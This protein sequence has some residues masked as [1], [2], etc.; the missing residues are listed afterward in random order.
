MSLKDFL[1]SCL[2][3][4]LLA[5]ELHL[6]LSIA[7]GSEILSEASTFKA[8]TT[9]TPI[10]R[11]SAWKEE[12]EKLWSYVESNVPEVLA[13]T[14]TAAFDEHLK[15]VQAVLR[16][17]GAEK[18]LCSAGLFHSIYGTEGFQGFSL[19]LS[20]RNTIKDLIGVKAEKLCFIFCMVDRYTGEYV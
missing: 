10:A 5:N 14:G 8:P 11:A 13:H 9:D 7:S 6:S 3:T 17:W 4:F 2:L 15:G 1:R 18:H 20:E 19:P 12:D 16:F